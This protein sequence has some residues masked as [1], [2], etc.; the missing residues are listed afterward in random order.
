LI[1]TVHYIWQDNQNSGFCQLTVPESRIFP[2]APTASLSINNTAKN[3]EKPNFREKKR[4]PR[5]GPAGTGGYTGRRRPG[6]KSVEAWQKTVDK[7]Q[8]RC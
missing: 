1:K 5:R 7:F 6:L 3:P 4:I 2:G 8:M